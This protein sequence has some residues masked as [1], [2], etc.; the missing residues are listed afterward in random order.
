MHCVVFLLDVCLVTGTVG[1][2]RLYLFM[3]LFFV[4]LFLTVELGFL[5]S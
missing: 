4:C 5:W 3:L 2:S 1:D